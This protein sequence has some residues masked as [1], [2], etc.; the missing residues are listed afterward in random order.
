MSIGTGL[1]GSLGVAEEATYGTYVA[2]TRWYEFDKED[3]KKV[4]ATFQGGGIA[5]GRFNELASRRV[6]TTVA[7]AGS[8]DVE[9]SNTKYGLLLQH[10][11]GSSATP[12]QDGATA[13]YTQ[14][15]DFGDNLGKYMTVQK[16]VPSTDGT[17]NPYTFLGGKVTA[18]TWT[19][20]LQSTLMSTIEWDF[21]DVTEAQSLAAPSY[22]ASGLA[23]FHGGQMDVKLGSFGSETSIS[24]VT[25][26]E[27]KI[28]RPMATERYYASSSGS[29]AKK[30]EPLTN[31]YVKITGS[32]TQD[33]TDKTEIADL[34]ASD[35]STSLVITWK[36]PL[37][38][39][40]F[41]QTFEITVPA[42]FVDSDTPSI[43]GR[44]VV[45]GQYAFTGQSDGTNPLISVVYRSTDDA[46]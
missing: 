41:Y 16:G 9:V 28:E 43:G 6:L 31:D 35:A 21:K 15:H 36:G 7:G 24:G 22:S 14:T 44:D 33:L 27:V 13:S 19:C 10:I 26:I 5:A 11:L 46:V 1:G 8:M 29:P 39:S 42:I 25:G 17:V 38:A 34:F 23:P 45:N 32:I 2:P 12:V 4:K 3:L 40:T 18:C 37:I 20:S 30:S